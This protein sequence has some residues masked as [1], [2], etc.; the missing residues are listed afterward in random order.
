MSDEKQQMDALRRRAEAA[1]RNLAMLEAEVA[2]ALRSL[3]YAGTLGEVV[4]KVARHVAHLEWSRERAAEER[5]AAIA[6]LPK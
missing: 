2:A 4:A 5:D 3:S 6:R 1:E